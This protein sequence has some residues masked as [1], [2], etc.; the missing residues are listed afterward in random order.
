[1]SSFR[2]SSRRS[3]AVFVI[4]HSLRRDAPPNKPS[5]ERTGAGAVY[6]YWAGASAGSSATAR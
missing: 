5:L 3:W 1:M 4:A 2:A 6:S